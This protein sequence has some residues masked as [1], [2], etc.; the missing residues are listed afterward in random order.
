V[1]ELKNEIKV[2]I[3][4]HNME[5]NKGKNSDDKIESDNIL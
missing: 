1:I 4:E 3:N 5:D 2:E